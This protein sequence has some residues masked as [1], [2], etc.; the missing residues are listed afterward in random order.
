MNCFH[1]K[2]LRALLLVIV[3]GLIGSG[4]LA[5]GQGTSASLTGQV[6]DPS[7]A[8]V[9]GATVTVTNIDTNLA[10]TAKT[11]S[12]GIYLIR[13]LPIGKY[14]LAISAVGFDG[15]LQKGIA[16][17]VG[18]AATQ[19][20]RLKIG[21][22]KSETISVTADAELINTSSAELGTTV[23]EAAIAELPLNGRD[24]SSLV[25]LVPGTVDVKSHGGEGIQAGFS[26]STETG[27]ASSGGRQGSTFYMLDG[28]SNMDNYDALTSPFPNSDSTQEFKVITNNFSAAYGFSPGAVVIIATKSGTNQFHGGAFWFVRNSDLNAKDWFSTSVDPLKRNQFGAYIGG[29]V[30]KDKLFFFGNYQGTKQMTASTDLAT[31]TPTAAMLTGDFSGLVTAANA[32]T[33]GCTS[34]TYWA[35]HAPGCGWLTGPFM[36]VGGIPNQVDKTKVGTGIFNANGLNTA[37][38]TIATT[39]LPGHTAGVTQAANGAMHYTEAAVRN[40]FNEYTAKLD[41]D[42]SPSQ[43][44]TLRSFTDEMTAPSGDTP[45]DMLS[46]I[47]DVGNWTYNFGQR[48]YYFND[49]LS[50]T[51]TINQTT[52]NT[53]SVFWTEMSA[54]NS[55]AVLDSNNKAMCLSRYI[56]V[57]ELPGQCYMEG[58]TVS[59]GGFNGG[60][61]EPSQEVRNTYGFTDTLN[62]TVKR[63]T[64]SAGVNLMHQF[65]E[66]FTQYP[67]TP[68][69]GFNGQYTGNGL[70]DFLLG[71]MSSYEQGGGEIADVTG[72]QFGPY[73]Q[74]DW[75][76]RPN[77]TFNLGLRWDPNTPPTSAGGRGA[78]FVAGQQS[79][80]FPNAPVGLIFPGDKGITST[81]MPASYGYWEPR[82][83][84]VWQPKNL[85]KTVVHAGIGL[86]TGP[87][88][89]S[90]YNH[91]AD[92]APFSPTFN[93]NGGNATCTGGC[94]SGA[95]TNGDQAITGQM[96]FDNPW[97]TFAGTGGVSPFPPFTSVS[98]KPASSSKFATPVS[99]LQS[100]SRDFKMGMTQSWNLSVEQQLSPSM[101]ARL[102]YVG[103]ESYHQTD[104]ID[105][106]AATKDV[107]P[108][109]NY[110]QILQAVSNGTAS[111]NSLQ[112]GFER[113][114][115]HGLQV[116]SNFT[117]S[118]S[119]DTASSGNVTFG[120]PY[121]GDP[122]DL[123]WNRGNSTLSMP[124]NW[125][126]N[127]IYQS[128]SLKSK[129]KLVQETV[130]GW[131]LSSIITFQTGNPFTINAAGPTYNND[132]SGS[133]QKGD[134]ADFVPGQAINAGKGSHWDWVKTGYFNQAAFQNNAAGTFG[135]TPKN[136]MYGPREFG[137][138]AAIMKT[139]SLVGSTNLQ[140]RWEAFNATNH[141]SFANPA[142]PWGAD[143]GWGGF[144]DIVQTGNIPARVM[145]GAL[146]LTF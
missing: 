33:P 117:W 132:D 78:A 13:P 57:N 65:A 12:V 76:A 137:V 104:A 41:Y 40:T 119:I 75:K 114:M 28:V 91:S 87:L 88:Q 23:G 60:W 131:E 134:R 101:V 6:T 141:P 7:G 55:A 126:T 32:S 120:S 34:P 74:D 59:N 5:H 21:A 108:F 135:N 146:K 51:W 121:L 100:F 44:V 80:M 111:Y 96:S 112:A 98:Y 85:P 72:W 107:R 63:H 61:T 3:A 37:A 129:S 86:F 48:M 97:S 103:S 16:L 39:G 17:T 92:I 133:L 102:A 11:D 142:A 113:H 69:V 84:M 145:Q 49:V 138:D 128:P 24:P 8:A 4:I 26:F 50:H 144:G 22:G 43:R 77:L 143:V 18:L 95:A 130:G 79:T 127:F 99:L 140:F 64:L 38:W 89:Y 115:S 123:R 53:F 29:P 116:Q 136:L 56:N 45:G 93:I 62:K 105:Q 81:L 46:V 66:E 82:V 36:T 67:T 124:W 94:I 139:W 25:F 1:A 19:D 30:I 20:V 58:F 68:I 10:Q 109:S 122:F 35:Y 118:K 90:Y 83:G 70:A 47:N 9:A 31:N 71:Y 15:Y 42:L 2:Y 54:H 110:A 52:V 27:A 14:T 125:V 73:F 106:N